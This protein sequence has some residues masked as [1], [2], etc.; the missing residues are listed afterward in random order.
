MNDLTS[1]ELLKRIDLLN[2]NCRIN[3]DLVKLRQRLHRPLKDGDLDEIES[4]INTLAQ[5]I[6]EYAVHLDEFAQDVSL[7]KEAK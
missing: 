6:G 1:D 5:K 4:K 7:R 3:I 2:E